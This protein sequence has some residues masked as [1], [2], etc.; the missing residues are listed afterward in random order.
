MDTDMGLDKVVVGAGMIFIRYPC[1]DWH[2][3]K[4]GYCRLHELY[5]PSATV[6]PASTSRM[7]EQQEQ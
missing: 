6:D 4:T 3:C 7:M 5:V 1:W 2:R